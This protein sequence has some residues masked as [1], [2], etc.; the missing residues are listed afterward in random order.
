MPAKNSELERVGQRH[1][2]AGEHQLFDGGDV[3]GEAGQDVAELASF[4]P[5][6]GQ[7]LQVRKKPYPQRRDESLA[8]P[9]GEVLVDEAHQPT[10]HGEP[11]V[12]QRHRYEQVVVVRGEHVVY[13]HFEQ[14]DARRGEGGREGDEQQAQQHPAAER[15]RVGP[16][17]REH[18]ADPDLRCVLGQRRI[19]ALG[20]FG[21]RTPSPDGFAPAIAG[22]KP[23]LPLFS[24]QPQWCFLWWCGGWQWC[25]F[26]WRL[27]G[28]LSCFGGAAVVV[29]SGPL[30]L[31]TTQNRRR[32]RRH[33]MSFLSDGAPSGR[34]TSDTSQ[35]ARPPFRS[36]AA[37]HRNGSVISR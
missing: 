34:R 12:G 1:V 15:A 13:Q 19:V 36:N 7:P 14:V 2:D 17:P 10:D 16:E 21:H 37:F 22:A 23:L 24:P 31:V 33:G 27:Q 25:F 9:G 29:R 26:R 4:E 3:A 18:R 5:P 35:A 28:S 11:N 6:D 32:Q 20:G 30:R 8:H